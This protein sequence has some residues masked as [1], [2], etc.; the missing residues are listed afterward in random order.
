MRDASHDRGLAAVATAGLDLAGFEI[1][2]RA[3][4]LSAA[5]TTANPI[6]DFLSA[7]F[8]APKGRDDQQAAITTSRSVVEIAGLLAARKGHFVSPFYVCKTETSTSQSIV[9]AAAPV[10]FI[11]IS[12]PF[13]T[14]V[15]SHPPTSSRAARTAV[16]APR[17]AAF[18]SAWVPFAMAEP[19]DESWI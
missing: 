9:V 7:R 8:A 15:A 18:T 2:T 17:R 14:K 1:G 4:G 12:G 13:A 19:V 5:V 11:W 16:T 6:D 3:P 10:T